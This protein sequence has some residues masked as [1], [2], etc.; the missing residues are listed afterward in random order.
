MASEGGEKASQ[1]QVKF[2]GRLT[3]KE[4]LI[5]FQDG[6]AAQGVL[7]GYDQYTLFLRRDDGLEVAVFKHAVKYVHLAQKRG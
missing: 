2:L 3:G 6:K 7:T 1:T 4:V 5:V